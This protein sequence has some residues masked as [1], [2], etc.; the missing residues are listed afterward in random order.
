MR[1]SIAIFCIPFGFTAPLPAQGIK[2]S[3][4]E[5][6]SDWLVSCW[7]DGQPDYAP[8]LG[9]DGSQGFRVGE[10]QGQSGCD[11]GTV[12]QAFVI[13]GNPLWHTTVTFYAKFTQ[14]DEE[15]AEFYMGS[16]NDLQRLYMPPLLPSN[17]FRRYSFSLPGCGTTDWVGF[18]IVESHRAPDDPPVTPLIQ[19]NLIIDD[20]TCTC[21]LDDGT[22]WE[23]W[24]TGVPVLVIF[25][26]QFEPP[27]RGDRWRY[28]YDIFRRADVDGNAAIELTD[29]LVLLGY[30][31]LSAPPPP[32]LEAGDANDDGAVDLGDAMGI[33]FYYFQ[34]VPVPPSPGPDRCGPDLTPDLLGCEALDCQ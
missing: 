15:V 31:F 28:P 13:E 29:V 16:V 23:L 32:C 19:S 21:T 1:S 8:D 30:L 7:D 25:G 4:F 33:L 5:A 10:S 22:S 27:Q 9:K 12:T 34:F 6:L 14:Q 20:V 17:F 2:N 3:N 24:P 18:G 26:A 11:F